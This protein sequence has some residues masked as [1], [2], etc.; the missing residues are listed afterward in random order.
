MYLKINID[1][2]KMK[3]GTENKQKLNIKNTKKNP[4]NFDLNSKLLFGLYWL[5]DQLIEIFL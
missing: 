3:F 4:E 5:S 2:L 1:C